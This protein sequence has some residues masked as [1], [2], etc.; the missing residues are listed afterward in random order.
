MPRWQKKNTAVTAQIAQE[1]DALT[2]LI[3]SFKLVGG[4]V[5]ENQVTQKTADAA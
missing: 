1:V 4:K 2:H 3:E 5:S